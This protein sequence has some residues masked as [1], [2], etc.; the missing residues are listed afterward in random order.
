MKI[1]NTIKNIARSALVAASMVGGVLA[2]T[3]EVAFT[4]APEAQLQAPE[5]KTINGSFS[6]RYASRYLL[7]SG[8]EASK[9]PV[10]QDTLKLNYGNAGLTLTDNHDLTTEKGP[11]G[12]DINELRIIPSYKFQLI[13]SVSLTQDAQLRVYPGHTLA[14]HSDKVLGTTLVYN[15][16]VTLG[17]A[18][19]H[20]FPTPT[21]KAQDGVILSIAKPLKLVSDKD[22]TVTLTPSFATDYQ[23]NHRGNT[24]LY[25]GTLGTSLCAER[26]RFGIETSVNRQ[27]GNVDDHR[28]NVN[29]FTLGA[30][31]KF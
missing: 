16:P 9:G 25:Y 26:G 3:N 13:D 21:A 19:C 17:A 31:V 7:G 12:W 24:G 22:L 4:N 30:K 11:R 15:G 6:E 5:Q 10:L 23:T 28:H 27:M 18:Y 20:F 29:Y 2:G 14:N 8:Y 1:Q